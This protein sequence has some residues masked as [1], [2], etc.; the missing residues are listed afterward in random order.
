[1]F[2]THATILRALVIAASLVLASCGGGGSSTES[3]QKLL[4][5]SA[6][7]VPNATGTMCVDPAP[8]SCP[9]GQEANE[10][11]DG[12]VPIVDDSLPAPV[13]TAGE[14]QAVLFY[15][16]A[17]DVYD[18][19][20]LHIWNNT[21]CD[22]YS[23]EQ[24]AGVTWGDGVPHTGVDPNYGAYWVLELKEGYTDCANYI[25]HDG[26]DKEQGGSDKKLDLSAE[27]MG[28]VLQG[29]VD[30]FTNRL[31]TL[32]VSISGASA[33]WV[34]LN[35]LLWNVVGD[36]AE[37]RIHSSSNGDLEFDA[38]TG[39]S[40]GSAFSGVAG[41]MSDALKAQLP[42]LANLDAYTMTV[43]AAVAK[44][45]L[46]GELMAVA[47]DA[48]GAPIGATR[49]Q[50]PGV[51]DHLYTMGDNDADEADLGVIY[52]DS[53]IATHV[54]APTAT[55]VNLKVYNAD[56]SLANTYAMNRDDATGIWSFN[57][58][59]SLDRKFY[60]FEVNVFDASTSNMTTVEATDPYSLSLSTNGRFSQF[61]NLNDADLFPEGWVDHS[62]P[63]INNPEDAVIYEGH[64]RDFSIWDTT[65]SEAN[66]GKYLAFTEKESDGMKHLAALADAGMTH[67]HMLPA[68]DIATINENASEQL[69][70]NSTVGELCVATNATAPVCGKFAPEVIIA[71]VLEQYDPATADAQALINSLRGMDAFNWGYDPQHFTAPEGSYA[72]DP[73]GVARIK[74][75]RAMNQALH[76][77]GLRVVLDV[78]YNHT[79]SSGFNDNSVFDK[80]VPGYYH[81]L[82]TETGAV[83]KSTCC[84]NLAPENR[85]MGKF[86]VDSL[87]QLTEAYGFDGYRFDIM[88]HLPK[89]LMLE[90][91][92]A[93]Q[94]VDADNYF[95]GEGWNFGEVADD[96]RFE[97]AT[98]LNMGGTEIGSFN[99]R[100]REAIRNADPFKAD[101]RVS[102]MDNLRLGMAGTLAEYVLKTVDDVAVTGASM[103][104][105][106]QPAGF[107]GD[108][109]DTINYVSKHDNET[110]WDKLQY[111]LPAD[112]TTAQRVRIQNM[113][114]TLPL[115]SQGIP[116]LQLGGDMI[117]SKSMDRN[118]YDSGDW[119]N[120]VDYTQQTNNWNVGLP[121]AQDNES[122]WGNIGD[123]IANEETA[124]AAADI[125]LA[126]DVFNEF[127]SIR[128]TSPLFRLTTAQDII[129]RVG[130]H[131]IGSRQVHGLVV[132]SIDDGEGLADLDPNVDAI[133]VV[134][135]GTSE[136][137]S[138][139]V[140]TASGFELHSIQANSA[141]ETVRS[142]S[143]A[144]GAFNVPAY[145]MAVFVKPQGEMQG[146]GLAANA[147]SGAAEVVP[148][149][150]TTVYLR[151]DMNGWGE[152]NAF[153]YKGA[154]LYTAEVTLDAGSYMFKV[155]SSDWSTVNLG[156]T[157][158]AEAAVELGVDESLVQNSQDNFSIT[159]TDADT[160]VFELDAFNTSAP[161]L[162]VRQKLAFGTN[163]ILLRGDMNGWDESTDFSYNGKGIYQVSVALNA[164]AYQFKVAT[165]DWAT[166]NLGAV[167]ADAAT[168]EVRT[169]DILVQDS[170]TNFKTTIATAGSY[171]FVVDA[172]FETQPLIFI[173]TA[174]DWDDDGI[175]NAEDSDIDGDGV[176]NDSDDFPYNKDE[177]VDTDGD[178]LGDNSD[179]FP[180][181][182]SEQFDSDGDGIG[183]NADT[184][185]DQVT[186]VVAG[187]A[188]ATVLLR[189][190]MNGWGTDTAFA[191]NNKG[192]YA[193]QVT[194]AAGTYGF[195]LA[196]DDW[197]TVNLGA[198][199]S[200]DITVGGSLALMQDSQTNLSLVVD[201]D[202]DYVFELDATDNTAP[203]LKVRTAVPY[204]DTAVFIRG[205]MNGWSEDNP[206]SYQEQGLYTTTLTLSAGTYGFKF[207][208]ADW[209]TVNFGAMSS[210]S[211]NVTIG[212]GLELLR[213]SNDNLSVVIPA[214]GEYVFKVN[215]LFSDHPVITV[216]TPVPYGDTTVFLRGDMNGWGET[217]AFV[218]NE[219][220]SAYEVTVSLAAGTYGFKFASADWSTVNF[221]AASASESAV[222]LGTAKTLAQTN[223][224]LSLEVTAAS[225][226]KFSVTAEDTNAPVITVTNA[227][228]FGDNT[229]LLRG[230]MNGWGDT[231]PVEYKG[232]GVYWVVADLTGGSTYGFKFA[233]GDW[234][235]VNLG[236]ASADAK[237]LSESTSIT[238]LQNSQDN[239]SFTPALDGSYIFAIDASDSSAP[240][241]SVKNQELFAGSTILLRGDMNGW[242]ESSP[243]TYNNDGTYSVSA[244][245]TAGTTY[246]FKIATGDWSTFNL[247]AQT[248]DIMVDTAAALIQDSQTNFSFTPAADS[249]YVFTVSISNNLTPQL[250]ISAQ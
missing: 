91:R 14:N 92:A 39:V 110:L 179:V 73:D 155:A 60:R 218:Y 249:S 114:A 236:A 144:D 54:W 9:S 192:R 86:V 165:A 210:E 204:S 230:D 120:K 152:L 184:G 199:E 118:T 169:G 197:S 227:A 55:Q 238:L 225:E 205:D 142:A 99:D 148:Y 237:E 45:A 42:H 139:A 10:F 212:T 207:A 248:A 146:A 26:D 243:F 47:Y 13:V 87:V 174:N 107:A 167:D 37:V 136:A 147:T 137:Q 153:N 38:E 95:Y 124:V 125:A 51:L 69:N 180:N 35:T 90:A 126:S 41:T 121:I 162:T 195:K 115:M 176:A 18:N 239:L 222:T 132:M 149:G 27:R 245:L 43:D 194:L 112:I 24:T 105:N 201:T 84:E 190:D 48:E 12:C 6:G 23:D 177:T 31:L 100:I 196:T 16:R 67:F 187:F 58:D 5:C 175:V 234:S 113:A 220:T 70:L 63:T 133:V 28:W 247:G 127:L 33:H 83:E 178:G 173:F 163:T 108:P 101:G 50:I 103:S 11:N 143:F 44:S 224:N 203:T 93:V 89:D 76:E 215:A 109:A 232:N 53:G 145:T 213:G 32:G 244:S 2:I 57:G 77:T 150:A 97:Q 25:I 188:D 111:G 206:L 19:W 135:N 182:S 193:V 34:D 20:K 138:H 209:S 134:M 226:Y 3:G 170:Q 166:V 128:S 116:F 78:V 62:V 223:D 52:S 151:G 94:S 96:A 161:V 242:D 30:T 65:V 219:A 229:V 214:D 157:S 117:R 88:G 168:V 119:F 21:L 129:D 68:N 228:P 82:N 250:T 61:V 49:I 131:N 29:V 64:I 189:G 79:S 154:G 81:R 36:V 66:R 191:S 181:D 233:T 216:S 235:T 185:N 183:D 231:H 102:E 106:G 140:N 246:G 75:M 198:A 1:M 211:T 158:G 130:F 202:G 22:A 156:A 172:S 46:R 160:Y 241:V 200:G 15:N 208:S 123:L 8:I 80:I 217:S 221:G 74:E 171:D 164:Q 240:V 4:S 71:D 7:Q 104:W 98:M 56:K 59:N 186:E 17:D 159:I 85:M 122:Q 141:D 72:S 40:G